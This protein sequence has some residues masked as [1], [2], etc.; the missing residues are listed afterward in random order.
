MTIRMIPLDDIRRHPDNPKAD[1][2]DT[3]VASIRRWGLAEP[4]VVDQRTGLNVSGHGRVDAP[5]LHTDKAVILSVGFAL[6]VNYAATW[7]CY[8]GSDQPCGECGSCTERAEAFAEVERD[9][10][11]AGHP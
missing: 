2:V 1:D 7:T 11:L 8:V 6:D 3:I 10:P 5:F 4:I 9:D